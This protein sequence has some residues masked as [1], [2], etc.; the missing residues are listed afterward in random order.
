MI[1]WIRLL[2]VVSCLSI[3]IGTSVAKDETVSSA[4]LVQFA[5]DMMG[6]SNQDAQVSGF[7]D[8]YSRQIGYS[9]DGKVI[10]TVS[11]A[12]IGNG[13]IIQ[14]GESGDMNREERTLMMDKV[15]DA[16]FVWQW[17]KGDVNQTINIRDSENVYLKQI[18]G[19][20]KKILFPD[21]QVQQQEQM[22]AFTYCGTAV[23]GKGGLPL[24]ADKVAKRIMKGTANDH[25]IYLLQYLEEYYDVYPAKN[26]TPHVTMTKWNVSQ[27]NGKLKLKFQAY[28][29]GKEAYNA[30]L[31]L[32][33]IQNNKNNNNKIIN[34]DSN[35][36]TSVTTD[37][38]VH[39]D[40]EDTAA[41]GVDENTI[42]VGSYRVTRQ[43]GLEEVYEI[44]LNGKNVTDLQIILRSD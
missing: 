29:F 35:A 7:D 10:Q 24:C 28:N 14:W 33:L 4:D 15:G 13:S 18:V 3:L 8:A 37:H 5:V 19:G 25:D 17:N 2:I 42:N 1:K 38:V 12:N 21:T 20:L 40:F 22:G 31:H 43:K 44:P 34:L 32:N 36:K 27:E 23:N 6:N 11:Y 41:A 9:S 16:G 30:T 39:M 26:L